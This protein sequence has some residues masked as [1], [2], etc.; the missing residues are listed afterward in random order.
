[1]D[2]QFHFFLIN[3]SLTELGMVRSTSKTLAT[4]ISITLSLF[5]LKSL[6]IWEISTAVSFSRLSSNYLSYF[7]MKLQILFILMIETH[8]IS[9]ACIG[10]LIAQLLLSLPSAFVVFVSDLLPFLLSIADN[11]VGSLL[12]FEQFVNVCCLTHL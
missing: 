10:L 4:S 11:L 1:M 9:A 3:F 2:E 8:F 6:S 7:Y 5:A 12:G